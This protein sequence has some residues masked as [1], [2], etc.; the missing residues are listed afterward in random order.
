[1]RIRPCRAA[2]T[3]VATLLG[4]CAAIACAS[5]PTPRPD[6]SA[7]AQQRPAAA[8]PP[9]PPEPPAQPAD[10]G[11]LTQLLDSYGY[12]SAFVLRPPEGPDVL[13]HADRCQTGYL[14]ASTFKI[15]N[16]LIALET[17][18]VSGPD[19]LFEWDGVNRPVAAWNQD[20]TLTSAFQASAVW[21]YQRVAREVGRERMQSWV[22]RLGYGN[23]DISPAVDRFWLDGGM[24]ITPLQQVDFVQ[25]LY[26]EALPASKEHQRMVKRIMRSVDYPELPLH[27]KTGR[28][29][30]VDGRDYGWFVG[31]LETH[32]GPYFFATLHTSDA[33][34]DSFSEDRKRA[35]LRLLQRVG[36]I[37]ASFQVAKTAS[38]TPEPPRSQADG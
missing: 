17:G 12:Q 1:M 9:Q 21:Y 38:G 35:T 22:D 34:G 27:V 37:P 4:L 32:A 5:A 23:R 19:H 36:V 25:R 16:S 20:H 10:V 24:R 31:Y 18:V 29:G 15:P 3:T 6:T 13:L 33:P 26:E 11:E 30:M 14:P 28:T 8:P 7:N 2:T